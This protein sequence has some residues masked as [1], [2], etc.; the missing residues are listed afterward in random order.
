MK[1][2]GL[3]SG[4]SMDGVDVALIE[5]DGERIQ[6]FGPAG[7]WEYS[8]DEKNLLRQ[9]LSEASTLRG[10][11][12]RPGILAEAEILVTDIHAQ[13]VEAFLG[14][15]GLNY[16]DVDVIGF[17]GQTVL[18]QP[19]DGL[20]VQLGDGDLLADRTGRPVVY[21]FRAADM[22]AGGQGAPFAPVFHRALVQSS[23]LP[24]PAAVVNLGGI[25]NITY[26]GEDGQLLAFDTGPA[27]AM[28]DDWMLKMTGNPRDEN[29]W[30]AATGRADG[31]RLE[32]LLSDPYFLRKPP[33]SLD[34]NA[35]SISAVEGLSTADGA[36]TLTAFTVASLVCSLAHLP[37]TPKIFVLCGGGA[38]NA[39]LVGSLRKLLPGRVELADAIG[40]NADAIEAQAFAF[41][42]VR[43]IQELP[44]SFP[45][46]TGVAEPLTG[47]VLALPARVPPEA[48]AVH[49][50]AAS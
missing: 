8:D 24:Y 36:A 28:I 30:L 38:H 13:V 44:I 18:H 4:T 15:H 2:L 49:S 23:D 37:A 17:H 19:D 39:T 29:G 32:A 21:D 46:T 34:R 31:A 40:W 11:L 7:M 1:A 48:K 41:M 33:K 25:A 9:A 12:E 22:E 50:P 27:N 26:A 6:S 14:E 20:T 10:R 42:A 43:S 35:F 45:G 16:Q 3:M 5:T 47:G